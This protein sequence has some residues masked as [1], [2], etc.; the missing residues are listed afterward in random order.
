MEMHTAVKAST[1]LA[2]DIEPATTACSPGISS[3]IEAT[4]AIGPAGC[5]KSTT[6]AARVMTRLVAETE[7]ARC[8]SRSSIHFT[9]FPARRAASAISTMNMNGTAL[10]EAAAAMFIAQAY[11]LHMGVGHQ[12]LIFFTATLAAIGAPGIPEAGLVT[13][14]IVLKAVGLPLEGIGLLLAVD[15]FLDRFRTMINVWG[16]AVGA[17]VIAGYLGAPQRQGA[18]GEPQAPLEADAETP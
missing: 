11:G 3:T 15:W 9:G 5:R 7:A 14:V 8:S 17:A 6:A 16:D 1:A 2:S 4:R 10:Y 18:A 13:M 12:A